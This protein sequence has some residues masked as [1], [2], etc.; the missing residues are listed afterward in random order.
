MRIKLKMILLTIVMVISSTMGTHLFAEEK[1]SSR[2]MSPSTQVTFGGYNP[3]KLH[4]GVV[5]LLIDKKIMEPD[6]ANKIVKELREGEKTGG[7]YIAGVNTLQAF[8][9]LAN[10]L[11][12]NKVIT[13][14][15][16][17]Q[18]TDKA[19][20]SGGVKIGGYNVVV[21]YAGLLD[22]LINSGKINLSEG[23]NV[24]NEAKK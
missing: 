18:I 14:Q 11:I 9:K 7:V 8:E 24:L 1:Q 20:Q 12:K 5:R 22:T 23:Q 13:K 15:D 19:K 3:L 16:V 4:D 2:E 17:E 6:E 10:T 21:L